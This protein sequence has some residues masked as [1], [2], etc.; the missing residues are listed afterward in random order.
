MV[1][2]VGPLTCWGQGLSAVG[3]LLVT[4][5]KPR[6][7][8]CYSVSGYPQIFPKSFL[9]HWM[10]TKVISRQNLVLDDS[11]FP[12]IGYFHFSILPCICHGTDCPLGQRSFSCMG[13]SQLWVFSSAM[14][15]TND[16]DSLLLVGEDHMDMD[17]LHE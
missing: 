14:E 13:F 9:A 3:C 5:H 2:G 15:A 6:N 16:Q 10:F 7:P 17:I 8:L 4:K 11:D 12:G 1:P